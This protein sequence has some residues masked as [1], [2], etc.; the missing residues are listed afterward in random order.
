MHRFDFIAYLSVEILSQE[1]HSWR[2]RVVNLCRISSVSPKWKGS[3]TA[4]ETHWG[5]V[6]LPPISIFWL[7]LSPLLVMRNLPIYWRGF[8]I[9]LSE[10]AQKIPNWTKWKQ[11]LLYTDIWNAITLHF[12][13]M[14]FN[15]NICWEAQKLCCLDHMLF[16]WVLV[17]C[18]PCFQCTD[19]L[20]QKKVKS[21]GFQVQFYKGS[22]AW[23]APSA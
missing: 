12:P 23:M 17:Y 10:A 9:K 16:R 18:Q 14:D 22:K 1:S 8:S 4:W 3:I 19:Q 11:M 7:F 6:Q 15:T 2:S 13:V 21:S 20:V 5:S